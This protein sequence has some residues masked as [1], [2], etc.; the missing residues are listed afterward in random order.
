MHTLKG[1]FAELISFASE[2]IS[3]DSVFIMLLLLHMTLLRPYSCTL[4]RHVYKCSAK[5]GRY[6]VLLVVWLP[7]IIWMSTSLSSI[8][9]RHL[10]LRNTSFSAQKNVILPG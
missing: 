2:A 10:S 6:S 4:F 7:G 1:F 5:I 8:N 9:S 3:C